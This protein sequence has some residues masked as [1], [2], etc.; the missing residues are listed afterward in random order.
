MSLADVEQIA[1]KLSESDRALLASV[2]LDSVSL[3]SL[4]HHQPDELE[5]RE[6]ELDQGSVNEISYEELLK[7]IEAER[8]R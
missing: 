8:L 6:R 2:L 5:R 1:L 3:D 7:R 4:D